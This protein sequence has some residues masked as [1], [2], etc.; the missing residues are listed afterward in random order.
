MAIN[1]S[2]LKARL[3]LDITGFSDGLSG[4]SGRLGKMRAQFALAAGAAAGFATTLSAAAIVG[5]NDIDK[6]AKAARRVGSSIGGFRALEM[7]AGEAGVDVETLADAVQTMDREVAKGT[8]NAVGSLGQLGIAAADLDGLEADEKMALISD[9]IKDLGLT[10]GQASS[11]LQGLGIKNKEMLLAVMSG[12]DV[13]RNARADVEA[14]GLAL[15]SVESDK[16]EVANDAIGRLALIGK[17]LGQELALKIVPA[18][19]QMA[20]A[21]TDSLREGGVLRMVIDG[22]VGSIGRL[23]TYLAVAVAGFGIR[24]VA[25][26]ALAKLATFSFAGALRFL[27]GALISTGIGALVVLAGELVYQFVSLVDRVGG[28][29]NAMALLKD[30]AVEV[31]DRIKRGASLMAE[32]IAGSALSI[33]AAFAGAFAGVVEK[34]AGMTKAIAKGWNGLMGM[35]GIESNAQGMGAELATGLRAEADA[36]AANA[37][38]FNDSIAASFGEISAPLASISALRDAVK[39]GADDAKTSLDGAA[40]AAD[41]LGDATEA[42]GGSGK[43]GAAIDALKDKAEE[44]K[45]KMEEVKGAMK[46]AFVGLVTGAKNL[47]A[48]IGELLGKFGEMLA[49]NAFEMLWTGGG[50]KDGGLGSLFSGLLGGKFANGGVFSGGRVQAFANGG[51]V[52]GATAFGM[53]GGMGIMGEAG[54]EAILPLSRGADGKLGVRA[55]GGGSVVEI[56]LGEGLE[57]RLLNAAAGQSIRITQAAVG[58]QQSALGGSISSLNARGTT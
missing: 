40:D 25:A 35:M 57:A 14:Y 51:V 6:V 44:L 13:F 32:A 39:T 27:R 12:G 36:M 20:Q 54:P 26:L 41:G 1:L 7:A 30:V 29:G 46:S 22:L 23:S 4:A 52:S 45:A 33:N 17:Y 43:G 56:R 11:V 53:R 15:S 37:A 58:A 55:G 28:F 47:K 34:F 38:A 16:I 2:D 10:S 9:K 24:Y 48:T 8:K 21:L 3:R 42:A 49:N 50:R 19:G 5:A 18:L 31:W